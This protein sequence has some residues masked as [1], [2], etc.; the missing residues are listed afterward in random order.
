MPFQASSFSLAGLCCS[1]FV[2]MLFCQRIILFNLLCRWCCFLLIVSLIHSPMALLY[3][4]FLFGRELNT[5]IMARSRDAKLV[6]L[7]LARPLGAE[8]QSATQC[9][10][11][12]CFAVFVSVIGFCLSCCCVSF[13]IH[14]SHVAVTKTQILSTSIWS[15]PAYSAFCSCTVRSSFQINRFI[16]SSDAPLLIC[17]RVHRRNR[18]RIGWLSRLIGL[19]TFG[20]MIAA[21][22]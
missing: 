15:L 3:S 11:C 12:C 21:D 2:Q 7:S 17:A 4:T 9:A 14:C 16:H 6:I 8:E 5:A 22:F 20:S 19:Q 18:S 1:S 13:S 10:F